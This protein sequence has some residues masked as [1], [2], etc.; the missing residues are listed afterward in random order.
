MNPDEASQS[1]TQ[2]RFRDQARNLL[3][4]SLTALV[5]YACWKMVVPFSG[6]LTLALMLATIGRKL[7]VRL[8]PVLRS[9]TVSAVISV[10]VLF[11]SIIVP[12]WLLFQQVGVEFANVTKVVL[13]EVTS[14]HWRTVL[15][16][17]P[18][19]GPIFRYAQENMDLGAELGKTASSAT[20]I[21][22]R[23]LLGSAWAIT[24]IVFGT[25]ILFFFVRD[26]EML[27]RG[28][29]ALIPL[30]ESDTSRL[31]DRVH[32]TIYASIVG[33]IIVSASQGFLGGL[34]FWVLGLPSPVLWGC[35]M[36][37]FAVLRVMGPAVVWVPAAC[38]LAIQGDWTKAIVLALWGAFAVGLIDNFLYPILVG[39]EIRVHPLVIFLSVA[40]GLFAFG[41]PGILLG[42]VIVTVADGFIDIWKARMSPEA[43]VM[44]R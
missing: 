12:V 3:L 5:L 33:Q 40:G 31:L 22:S 27:I 17:M 23:L 29:R 16:D 25:F 38:A 7:H 30:P 8:L 6:S 15:A 19:L 10:V 28:A 32:I 9:P 4:L 39:Q 37:T 21:A 2:S 24:Q 41:V 36:A 34:M 11:A 14:G 42:P 1:D 18:G 35:V 13:Y 26:A 44:P 20:A 43:D